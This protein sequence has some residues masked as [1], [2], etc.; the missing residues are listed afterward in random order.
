MLCLYFQV[1]FI[2]VCLSILSSPP[3]SKRKTAAPRP[4]GSAPGRFPPAAKQGNPQEQP[5]RMARKETRCAYHEPERE[6]SAPETA[7]CFPKSRS[8]KKEGA[9]SDRSLLCSGM[10]RACRKR[11]DGATDPI[12]NGIS[13]TKSRTFL[14]SPPVSGTRAAGFC[15]ATTQSTSQ[16]NGCV[17]PPDHVQTRCTKLAVTMYN[18]IVLQWRPYVNFIL[19]K[20]LKWI[21]NIEFLPIFARKWD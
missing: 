15:R 21:K 18:C 13:V 20:T 2:P 9:G 12:N 4:Q 7:R 5:D 19:K 10:R 3:P 17:V 16:K 6:N 8:K 11:A 1:Y 14:K